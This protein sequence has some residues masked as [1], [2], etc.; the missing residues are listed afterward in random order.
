LGDFK[1]GNVCIARIVYRM[2]TKESQ[3]GFH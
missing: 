2:S 1:N 3:Q